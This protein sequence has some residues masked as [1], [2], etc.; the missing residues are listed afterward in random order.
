MCDWIKLNSHECFFTVTQAVTETIIW[1]EKNNYG[2]EINVILLYCLMQAPS[3]AQWQ[4]L[5]QFSLEKNE[6]EKVS[7]R[8]EELKKKAQLA[9]F[10]LFP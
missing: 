2:A 4:Q 5:F 10:I 8:F 3:A 1:G 9:Y 7:E 6:I